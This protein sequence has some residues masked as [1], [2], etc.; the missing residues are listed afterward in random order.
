MYPKSVIQSIARLHPD[1]IIGAATPQQAFAH[2][3]A[4][5]VADSFAVEDCILGNR[6][7]DP[8]ISRYVRFLETVRARFNEVQ[9]QAGYLNQQASH[10][11]GH[12][13]WSVGW[14]GNNMLPIANHLYLLKDAGVTGDV[15]ECGAFKGSSTACLSFACELLDMRLH[16]ADSFAGLPAAEGHYGKGD[17]YGSREEVERNVR[18]FGAIDRVNFIKGWYSESLAGFDQPLALI[19]MDVDLQQS[20]LDVLQHVYGNLDRNGVIFSDGCPADPN[21]RDGKFVYTGGE[22][23]GF[24]RFFKDHAIDYHAAETSAAGLALIIPKPVGKDGLAVHTPRFAYLR[25]RL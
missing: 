4:P 21:I 14:A 22:P 18:R 25:D 5:A 11:L 23:A 19:W 20:V 9:Q 7:T 24:H 17:F 12:D 6:T 15:L 13:R 2:R 10:S 8:A 16:C 3:F 1:W